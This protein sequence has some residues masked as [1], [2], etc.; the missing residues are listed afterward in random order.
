MGWGGWLCKENVALE[1]D[2]EQLTRVFL[3]SSGLLVLLVNCLKNVTKC[4]IMIVYYR[5]C[6]KSF[7]NQ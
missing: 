1:L 2:T 5:V 3:L 4:L 6:N 7:V